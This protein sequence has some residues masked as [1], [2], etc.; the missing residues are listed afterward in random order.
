M[1]GDGLMSFD[2]YPWRRER[3]SSC[4]LGS[5]PAVWRSSDVS[6]TFWTRALRPG[7]LGKL[8]C[9]EKR[10][11]AQSD[12]TG[13]CCFIRS[14]D[15]KMTRLCSCMQFKH[16][17]SESTRAEYYWQLQINANFW[18]FSTYKDLL[19]LLPP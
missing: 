18:S 10:G 8:A 6:V 19:T 2:N 16:L 15:S 11:K 7:Q 4:L 12:T 9:L 3:Y 14:I 1:T 17:C 5:S 13:K